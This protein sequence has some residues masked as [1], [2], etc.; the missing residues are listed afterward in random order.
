MSWIL[1]AFLANVL[2]AFTVIFDKF[3][4]AKK[5]KSVYSFGIVLNAVYFVFILITTYFQRNTFVLGPSALYSVVAGILWFFMWIFFWKALQQ[6]EASRVSA[7]FFTQPIYSALIGIS[8]LHESLNFLKW[9]GIVVIV[10]GAILS[11]LGGESHKKE[12]RT[13][14]LFALLAAVF[15]SVGNSVSKYAMNG[16]PPLTVNCIAFYATIP[17]YLFILKDK[18]ILQEVVAALT[19]KRLMMQ[20]SIR[21]LLGYVGIMLNMT[22]FGLGPLSL[23]TAIL[24]TQ[25]MVILVISLLA[26]LVFPKIIHEE[27]G[28]K[29]L[30]PKL[31]ALLL[32]VAGVVMI[33][34]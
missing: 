1:Y 14:Y 31:A 17:L 8:F 12:V 9:V 3:V 27:L 23:I 5:I 2:F 10:I 25:P 21:G 15:S 20:F 6:G 32:T 24:G 28:K 34:L 26:A 16:L 29:T 13:A 33:S 7:I 19:D 22:A 11:S 30:V 18:K 4:N